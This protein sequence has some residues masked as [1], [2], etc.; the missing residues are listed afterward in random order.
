MTTEQTALCNTIIHTA[1]LSA[2]AVGGGLAQIPC[3]DNALITP[4][5]ITMAISLGKVF[6]INLSES[7]AKALQSTAAAGIIGR[8]V[9][10]LLIGWIPGLGNITNAA[11]AATI[12][13]TMDWIMAKE[14]DCYY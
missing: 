10:Q 7:A 4:I 14:L 11:T 8:G 2:A 3:S 12:T 1:S 13:E 9:S 5:Q 6:D